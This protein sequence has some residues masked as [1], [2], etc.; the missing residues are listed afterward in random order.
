MT[1]KKILPEEEITEE[2][3]SE[4]ELEEIDETLEEDEE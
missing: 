1:L 3:P 4:E 2:Y